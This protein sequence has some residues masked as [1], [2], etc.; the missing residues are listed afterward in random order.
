[1]VKGVA[2]LTWKPLNTKS[3]DTENRVT[4]NFLHPPRIGL[5]TLGGW[6]SDAAQQGVNLEGLGELRNMENDTC[7]W[8]PPFCR[9]GNWSPER[10]SDSTGKHMTF[11][12]A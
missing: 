5:Q 8:G 6:P 3:L 12:E 10:E 4:R 9:Q 2:K 11:E 1:M 7:V